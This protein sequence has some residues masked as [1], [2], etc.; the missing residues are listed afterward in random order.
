LRASITCHECDNLLGHG[1]QGNPN[2][3]LILLDQ[4]MHLAGMVAFCHARMTKV[5]QARA[6]GLQALV[7]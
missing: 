1:A 6:R 5:H 7:A 2:P 4:K 3:A